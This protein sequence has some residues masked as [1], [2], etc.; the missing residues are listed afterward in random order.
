M[1]AAAA[2][3]GTFQNEGRSF[4]FIC[5]LNGCSCVSDEILEFILLSVIDCY[6]NG[7]TIFECNNIILDD[8]GGPTVASG[9]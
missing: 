6:N 5:P 7:L 9:R 8:L 3:R 2:A 1:T 4:I